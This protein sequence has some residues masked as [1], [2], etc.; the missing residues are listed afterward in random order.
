MPVDFVHSI[1]LIW[2][3]MEFDWGSIPSWIV[4]IS[5]VFGVWF[6]WSGRLLKPV[7]ERLEE[8]ESTLSKLTSD[9]LSVSSDVDKLAEK[10]EKREAEEKQIELIKNV[11]RETVEQIRARER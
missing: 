9:L 3:K 11:T 4:A 6:T 1:C 10:E 5:S 7:K 8:L 2:G